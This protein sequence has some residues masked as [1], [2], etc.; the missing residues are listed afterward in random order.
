MSLFLAIGL[1]FVAAA[2]AW[3][4]LFTWNAPVSFNGLT[5]NQIL[6]APSGTIV[7]AV[8]FGNTA[9]ITV[10]LTA[11]NAPVVFGAWT[12]PTVASVTIPSAPAPGSGA[13]PAATAHTTGNA[14]LDAV[15]NTFASARGA[16]PITLINLQ[17]GA[18]YSVQLFSVDDRGSGAA[19]VSFQ[20]P[21]DASDVSSTF[22]ESSNSYILG[23]FTV[24]AGATSVTLQENLPGGAGIINAL[25]VRAVSFTP[26][27]NFTLQPVDQNLNIGDTATFSALATGPAPLVPQWQSGPAGGPYTN[28]TDGG[29]ISGSHT[30]NLT[31]SNI[32]QTDA[33]VQYVLT[34]TSGS[35]SVTS[36]A[37]SLAAFG[38]AGPYRANLAPGGDV[39]SAILQCYYSGGGIV[40][41][42][43]GTYY[44][45]V[46][47]YP[48]VTLKGSGMGSTVIVGTLT[49]GQ[50]GANMAMQDLTVSGGI[51]ASSYSQGGY[52]SAGI[53]FGAY[54]PNN[55]DNLS[56]KNVEVKGTNIAMQLI[57]VAGCNL[58]GCNFHD[59]GLGFSHTIYF[60][61][62]Y[63]VNMN[64]C[65]AS[66]GFAG[67]GAHL[68]FSSDINVAN[69]FTQCEFN[70]ASGNGILNQAYNG[71]ANP[72]SITGCKIQYCGQS[73]GEGT[74][75]DTDGGGSITASRLE[76]NHGYG[77]TIRDA[78]GLF[79]DII[80]GN[81]TDLFYSYGAA[82]QIASGTT[83]NVYTAASADGVSGA[84]NTADWV[85]TFGG[86][87]EGAVA[88]TNATHPV[89]GSITWPNVSA[90]SAGNYPLQV[91]YSNGS[92]N[93]LAMPVTVNGAYAGT[94]QFPP[95]GSWTTYASTSLTAPLTAANNSVRL[96]VLSPGLGTPILSQLKVIAAVPA[97]PGALSGLTGMADRNAPAG[98]MVTWIDLSWTPTPGATWYNISRNGLPIATGVSTNS[99]IDKHVLGCG[100]T[101][102][103]TVVPV[104]T[105]GSGTGASVTAVSLAASPLASSSSNVGTA[106]SVSWS[107][108]PG[109]QE[110]YIYRSTTSGG[111]Y[112]CIGSSTTTDYLDTTDTLGTTYYYVVQASNGLSQSLNSPETAATPRQPY[113]GGTVLVDVDLGSGATQSGGAVLG[114]TGDQ[115]NAVAGN[116]TTIVNSANKALSGV[117]LTLNSSGVF[118]DAGG[119]AMD[120]ATTSLMQ[121]YAYGSGGP[122][123]IT[124]T[125]LQAYSD[126]DF[127][128]VVYAAGDD[129]G[130][131]ASVALTSG[132][133]V[134]NSSTL[135]TSATSRSV[136]AG[137]G[138]AYVT[139]S[140]S[141]SGGNLTI[142][143]SPLA[144]QSFAVINGFQLSL[145]PHHP[146]AL[147]AVAAQ[148][149]LVGQT[150]NLQMAAS[151]PAGLPLTYTATGLPAGLTI[152]SSGLISGT[153]NATAAASNAV[154]VTVSDGV[155][156][157]S[158]S[159]TWTTISPPTLTAVGAQ[160]TLRG[161]TASLQI[162]ASD[163]QGLPLTY[164]ATGLPT[165][166]SI[167]A[168]GL[169]S[170]TVSSSAAAN[171]AVT[172]TVNDGVQSTSTSF[173]WTTTTAAPYSGS[174]VL[175]DVDLGSGS[176]QSGAAVLGT[177][178]D[179]WN[180]VSGSTTNMVTSA[181]SALSGVGLTLSSSGVYADTGG[182][183]MDAATTAL[184]QGYAYGYSSTPKVT[185]T[186]TGLSAYAGADFVLVVYAAGDSAGQGASIS[187]PSG[188]SAGN[189]GSASVVSGTS[190]SISAG[191]GVA[192]T[193][194][195][196][197]ITGGNLTITASALPGQTF[198]VMNGFQLK[199]SAQVPPTIA[200]VSAQSTARGQA[201]SL[202]IAASDPGGLP[203]TYSASGLP[204]G[205]SINAAGLISGTVSSSAAA[206][207]AVTVT[208]ND[209]VLSASTNFTWATTAPSLPPTIATVAA[210][211]TVRGQT[212]S[213]QISASDPQGKAL[214]YTAGGLPTGL[215]IN[216]AGL[217]S[218][219]VSSS[220]AS[221][222]A[223]TVTVNDGASSASTS[224]T[225]TTTAPVLTPT[226]AAVAAQSTVRGQAASLQISA[227]DPQGKALTYT[228][229]GLPTGLS[230]KASGLISGTVS[231]SA[232]ASNAVT[233]TVNDGVSSASTT[234][235]WTTTAPIL[236]PTI[237]A[238]AA[239]RTARG[240]SLKLQI[241][242]KDP[243][244]K[245]LTYTASG[246]PAGLS[247]S[248]SGLI[249]GTVSFSAASSNAVTVT[250][251][252]GVLSAS[253]RFTWTTTGVQLIGLVR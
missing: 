81:S 167:N 249:S 99:F 88:F 241:A 52:P 170:G 219:T 206:S 11:N 162:A 191:P 14:G 45:S 202:Q 180:A 68:D 16:F 153:V 126:A 82:A 166:L 63:A 140:G 87:T 200:A 144:G 112:T 182:S 96:D 196:G 177:N 151:D 161:Q 85:T 40:T 154:S 102:T 122:V 109:A 164:T 33:S 211:S 34:L 70:G 83:P 231:T 49:Q 172:V 120:A 73:G 233:V 142:V 181:N 89:N 35:A 91:S 253:T 9:P 252:N 6:A 130:Q 229:S 23:T 54:Y 86:A 58:L 69:T 13:Y 212:A 136:S 3:A 243:Q 76:Y 235:T 43:P 226:I 201:A 149:T 119:T 72:I 223:V 218:G 92:T 31:I 209:G 176:P 111:P 213:L 80:N 116:T 204:T 2:P 28:L 30:Y 147:T 234:F 183:A 42:A 145:S 75:V 139:F 65:I 156:T 7:G 232:A 124:L 38:T 5:A 165:G 53:F 220:A 60:T 205:L 189:T 198:S 157:A 179:K 186:L 135:A 158:T 159:F 240:A 95:T 236:P 106:V 246:L 114:A 217:I 222:N 224:F 143:A 93:T 169:I 101:E 221:S 8:G 59:N 214:T 21:A 194:F 239:Q 192:Y 242:A 22:T 245:A 171:N 25:V 247:I 225:W 57:N 27:I 32:N 15:L 163:P 237:T 48:N 251:S 104:N 12:D 66:W 47:M 190:R 184:M 115:W 98:D 187:L 148:N 193:T 77:A 71:S 133:L 168:S 51:S 78:V 238:V 188:A 67:A 174:T 155:L 128:L 1:C 127:T 110:Y 62:D 18:T 26:A 37:A 10:T 185:V 178:G 24:P 203:L 137:P 74:G 125:G 117:G 123:T 146:P 216:A 19:Q 56:W 121:H 195:Y 228:A 141:I 160:N 173:T 132:V 90:P 244:G 131:G 208:V 105:A 150:A 50:Y 97:V 113:S 215:S 152:N 100:A 36:R 138:V 64:N 79:Y 44:G 94:L 197:T 55:S 250:V 39:N 29:R 118:T 199:L 20:D 4:G 61:G 107:A 41:L 134:E 248:A 129:A 46:N 230:I 227:T 17:P 103:Y 108:S 175:L 84:N 210:Q 207:N